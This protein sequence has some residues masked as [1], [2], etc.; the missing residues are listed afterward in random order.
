[1][2]TESFLDA[3]EEEL[4]TLANACLNKAGSALSEPDSN[5]DQHTKLRLLLE[6]QSCLAEVIRKRAEQAAERDRKR[7]TRH[8]WIEIIV[9][10]FLIGA[11]LWVSIYYGNRG[12]REGREQ[13]KVLAQM[14]QSTA[15]TADAMNA[16]RDSLKSLADAQAESLRI[17]QQQ[18]AEHA[19]KPR[20]ALLI[21]NT[22]LD[23][24]SIQLQAPAGLAQDTASFELSLKNQGDAPVSTFRL[25][26]LTPKDT[27]LETD[28][29]ITV[30]ESEPPADPNTVRTTLQLP[31][32]PAGETIR[33]HVVIYA[34][35]G[36]P[37]FKV[38]F[39]LDA[40]ELQAVTRLGLLTVLPPKP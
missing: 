16:A 1:M 5:F 6:A 33:I 12:V 8:F 10:A 7:E 34:K 4:L 37:A 2:P 30:P 14:Q 18:Q 26:A 22:P 25:H 17:L 11:E 32:L 35:K 3:T 9:V 31:S 15:A 21:G 28:R 24:A 13:S 27:S 39:T 20:L 38:P 36:Q 23:R 19:K 29:L 40:F